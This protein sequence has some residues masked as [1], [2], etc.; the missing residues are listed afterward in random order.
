MIAVDRVLGGVV[1][2]FGVLLLTYLIPQYVTGEPTAGADPKLFP[3][4]A[5][6]LFVV[7]GAVQMLF[8][9]SD[10][11]LPS[12]REVVRLT[13]F[14]GAMVVATL[15]MPVVGFLPYAIGL[16]AVVIWQVYE[17]RVMWVAVSVIAV[18]LCTWLLFEQVL[19]RP[20]P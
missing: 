6:W 13:L 2:A 17:R 9:A 1:C 15:L 8:V 20:L 18:P 10:K 12:L 11:T 4:I 7:L 16:M 3:Q 14:V 19:G 5:G